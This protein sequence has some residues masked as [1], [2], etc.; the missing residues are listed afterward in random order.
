MP[1]HA[2]R[3]QF[4]GR[5]HDAA[6]HPTHFGVGLDH[7]A[8]IDGVQPLAFQ[9]AAVLAEIPPRH[10]VLRGEHGGVVF[11]KRAHRRGHAGHRVRLEREQHEILRPGLRHV[12]R[13]A[14]IF[15]DVLRAVA[16]HEPQP[17]ALHR[18][19]VRSACDERDFFA[20]QRQLRAE[21][22]ADGAGADD[23]DFH[24]GENFIVIPK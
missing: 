21:I 10:A 23:A 24:V 4:G 22:P 2:G 19:E 7:A 15:C 5:I 14:D 9:L 3:G 16:H 6:D 18:R 20:S 8:G 13:G 1:H 12:L 11:V 17:I